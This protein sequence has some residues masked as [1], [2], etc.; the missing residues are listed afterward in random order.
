MLSQDVRI[1]DTTLSCMH[2]VATNLLQEVDDGMESRTTPIQEREDD[3]DITT[4]D[5]HMPRPSPRYKSA[6]TQSPRSVRIR[7]TPLHS[8]VDISLIWHRNEAYKDAL[9]RG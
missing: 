6:Q 4:L 2:Y 1:L 7:L 3:E 8:F 5:T 9:E